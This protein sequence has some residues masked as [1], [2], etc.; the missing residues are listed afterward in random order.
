VA[1]TERLNAAE[2]RLAG[3]RE[4]GLDAARAAAADVAR[5][6]VAKLTAPRAA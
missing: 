4:Q 3:Q 2:E 5:D 6:I 1:L